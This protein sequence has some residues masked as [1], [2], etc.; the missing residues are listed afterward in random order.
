MVRRAILR[1]L[2]LVLM[3][4]ALLGVGAVYLMHPERAGLTPAQEATLRR[5]S[6]DAPLGPIATVRAGVADGPRLIYVHGTP[7]DSDNWR[8]YLLEPVPGFT[9]IALDRPGF[10]ASAPK[11]HVGALADQAEAILPLLVERGGRRPLLVGHS[12]GAPIIAKLAALHSDRVGGLLIVAGSLDPELEDWHWYN[13]VGGWIEPL[14]PRSLRN[15]NRELRSMR[16]E[17]LVLRE[18]LADITCPVLILHGTED[19]LVPYANSDYTLEHLR[20]AE[21]LRRI[22][23]SG[24]DHFLIWNREQDVRDAIGTLAAM[25]SAR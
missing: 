21:P 20:G 7:G 9:S 13:R 16:E 18:Q 4:L 1:R 14:M 22:T 8:D 3:L 24:A 12:L 23:L 11:G 5:G 17:L 10:G 2:L 6:H 15:S 25:T 19:G